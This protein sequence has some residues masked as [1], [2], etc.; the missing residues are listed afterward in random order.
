MSYFE[1][2]TEWEVILI[3]LYFVTLDKFEIQTIKKGRK[4]KKNVNNIP[5]FNLLC[6]CVLRVFCKRY[7]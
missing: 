1:V 5:V 2:S 7:S 3:L 6:S 4:E